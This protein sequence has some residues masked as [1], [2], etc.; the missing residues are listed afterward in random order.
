MRQT[1]VSQHSLNAFLER[2]F[3]CSPLG[4]FPSSKSQA[5]VPDCAMPLQHCADC[6]YSYFTGNKGKMS[7]DKWAYAN[8]VPTR[9][10]AVHQ[11][12]IVKVVSWEWRW[13]YCDKNLLVRYFECLQQAKKRKKQK[14]GVLP[15]SQRCSRAWAPILRFWYLSIHKTPPIGLEIL[16]I[17]GISSSRNLKRDRLPACKK[18]RLNCVWCEFVPPSVQIFMY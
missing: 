12:L 13:Q 8:E 1:L 14:R 4:S 16:K 15:W 2:P 7:W 10:V 3:S 6:H 9:H 5:W 17:L 18:G 11:K